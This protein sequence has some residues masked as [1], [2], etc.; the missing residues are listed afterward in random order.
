MSMSNYLTTRHKLHALGLGRREERGQK[1]TYDVLI[2]LGVVSDLGNVDGATDGLAFFR[3]TCS[4]RSVQFRGIVLGI[5]I[6]YAG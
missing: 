3:L 1:G 4:I 6:I 2:L 5:T